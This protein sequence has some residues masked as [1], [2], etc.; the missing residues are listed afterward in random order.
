MNNEHAIFEIE[1]P[2]NVFNKPL[3]REALRNVA[4][5]SA[6]VVVHIKFQAPL[7]Y[8]GIFWLCYMPSTDLVN[9]E[10]FSRR[11]HMRSITSFPGVKINLCCSE[12]EAK[13]TIPFMSEYQ[14]YT[15]KSMLEDINY[16]RLC[17]YALTPIRY[18]ES[19]IKVPYIVQAQLANVVLKGKSSELEDL[20]L[21]DITYVAE[22]GE[23]EKVTNGKPVSI[24][25]Q[26]ASGV[27]AF[28]NA[29]PALSSLAK[30]ISW[31]AEAAVGVASLFGFSRPQ[32]MTS[33]TPYINAPLRNYNHLTGIDYSVALANY[34]N[35]QIDP[36]VVKFT[37]EDEMA[38]AHLAKI[39]YVDHTFNWAADQ[40]DGTV[41]ANIAVHPNC[42]ANAAYYPY[43]EEEANYYYKVQYPA[44][45]GA[46]A[47]K[48]GFWRG[49]MRINI[50]FAKVPAQHSGRLL[51]QYFPFLDW[52]GNDPVEK[53]AP[54]ET[55]ESDVIELANIDHDGHTSCFTTLVP[56]K[57]LYTTIADDKIKSEDEMKVDKKKNLGIG[58]C[59]GFVRI[60]VFNKLVASSTVAQSIDAVVWVSWPDLELAGACI[61]SKFVRLS[62]PSD[63]V[64]LVAETM[65]AG[66]THKL[67]TQDEHRYPARDES[68]QVTTMGEPNLVS[69]RAL[70]RRPTITNKHFYA[71]ADGQTIYTS[72]DRYHNDVDLLYNDQR[73]SIVDFVATF[74][75]FTH[76]S[77]RYKFIYTSKQVT[78]KFAY[79][80][81]IPYFHSDDYD[82]DS[83]D[84]EGYFIKKMELGYNTHIQDISL[85]P[86]VEV[87]LPYY[88]P[89]ENNILRTA[90][91]LE[92]KTSYDRKF[93][94][95]PYVRVHPDPDRVLIA[96]GDDCTFNFLMGTP[97]VT[98]NSIDFSKIE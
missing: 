62:K 35:N 14:Q 85:N 68:S 21:S 65:G 25:S 51:V 8:Q 55:V 70:S 26:V 90:N 36:T 12:R 78:H 7:N 79:A 13:L 66:S 89:S 46:V 1:F 87:S 88:T 93:F 59:G 18:K 17:L 31:V 45:I 9:A 20:T 67:T 96:T 50:Q 33:I 5:V 76:G 30:P 71:L 98:Y 39:P 41:L 15:K 40:A 37:E 2:K 43:K 49:N 58:V 95:K 54:T 92:G 16:A 48:V 74:Y 29:V 80:V 57:W 84:I 11:Y 4:F 10:H 3:I 42:P 73:E 72:K 91:V 28:A 97:P 44:P 81:L 38:V 23:E 32:T 24:V 69:L 22:T 64:E 60:S 19:G 86:V 56:N 47:S 94:T 27:S 61:G 83:T 63:E 53:A 75:L 77:F 6:D 52:D 82:K 34:P